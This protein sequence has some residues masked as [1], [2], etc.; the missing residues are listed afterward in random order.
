MKLW[1]RLE[2]SFVVLLLLALSSSLSAQTWTQSG[3][4]ARHSHT[5]VF[6]PTTGQSII[7]GGRNSTAGT[8]L[9]DLWLSVTSSKQ[10]AS[11]TSMVATGAAP[12]GRYGAVAT[13]DP[14][15]I[16]MTVFGGGTGSPASCMND[17]WVLDG[18]NGSTGAP[19]W[20]SLAASGG[21]P[22]ARLYHAAA[23]D[24]NTNTLI[25]FGG[26]NCAGGFLN[27]VWVLSNANGQGGT[28]AWTQLQPSTAA[29]AAREGSTAVYDATNNILI[30]YGGDA[31]GAPLGDVWTLSHA[32]GSG[33][34]PAWLQLQPTGTAPVART[35]H[36]AM[37]DSAVNRMTVFGGASSTATLADMWMLS[38][39]NGT[40]VT[41]SWTKVGFKG[42]A[43]PPLAFHSAVYDKKANAMYVFGGSSNLTKLGISDHTFTV[44]GVTLT[45]GAH[46][47]VLGGP[48]VRYSQ[49]LVYDSSTNSMF[50]F[51][52]QHA[53][54]NL[55]FNDYWQTS[56]IVGG[57]NLKWSLIVP[58][59][60]AP[61]VRFG[62]TGLYDSAS[63]R[64]MVFGGAL[65]FPS[66]CANDYWI[67]QNANNTL[68]P[69]WI[70]VATAGTAP[71]ARTR[72]VSAY[73]AAT[74][75]L[76]IF[77]GYDCATGY[78]NDVWV[79]SGANNASG[80]PIWTQ[81]APSGV[82]PSARQSSSAVYDAAT[83]SLI[84]FGGDAGSSPFAD[85]WVL[86]HASGSGGTP[87]WTQL[88]ASNKGAAAR[89]GHTATYDATN[90]RMTIYGGWG[91]RGLLSDVWV[92]SGANGQAGSP[93][94][95]K[96][97]AGQLRR[98]HGSIY[99]PV[100]NEMVTFGGTTQVAPQN[101]SSDAYILSGANGLP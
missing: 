84:V 18:A 55:N 53:N 76:I 65:G 40:G 39:A 62:H 16:R 29:P 91:G 48:P 26:S 37:Y 41:P 5:A 31:G 38:T 30:I 72:H 96:L 101:P 14:G 67:L 50:L 95:T 66:P 12:S 44:T 45:T 86:S 3:P 87:V 35:G 100:S 22:L 69:A 73:D 8:D 75:S 46:Q 52:G 34:T 19:S 20:I 17:L 57:P 97:S 71:A 94:W 64:M 43:P 63:N 36:T 51:G 6:D 98:F 70:S 4:V 47:F 56:G 82:A 23:Y 24:P 78:F 61:A 13:Y 88:T 93:S 15:T 74:N 28:P 9:N 68:K 90:N 89:S 27:D 1:S 59:G 11:F 2:Y 42:A 33:G 10:N 21:P 25:V 54:T 85:I 58:T 92:L 79:L 77:G 81:L 7:F 49:S 60:V 32:N 99:D 80:T 83:I